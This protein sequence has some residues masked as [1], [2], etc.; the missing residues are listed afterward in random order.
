MEASLVLSLAPEAEGGLVSLDRAEC[1]GRYQFVLERIQVDA[2][3]RRFNWWYVLYA[4]LC[5]AFIIL[6]TQ[7]EGWGW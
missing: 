3:M 2:M 7:M 1:A 4:I 6:A 5:L